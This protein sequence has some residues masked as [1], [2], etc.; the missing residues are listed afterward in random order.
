[1]VDRDKLIDWIAD[2]LT[3][4]ADTE[5]LRDYFYQGQVEILDEMDD[6]TLLKRGREL[7]VIDDFMR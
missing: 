6:E 2:T 3:D 5:S 1:M 7:G 4:E